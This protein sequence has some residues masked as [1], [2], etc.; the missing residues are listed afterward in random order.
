[1]SIMRF[2]PNGALGVVEMH[3][4][5]HGLY[6]TAGGGTYLLDAAQ[7]PV[8]HEDFIYMAPYCPQGFL[9]G[10]QGAEYLL[11]KDVMRDGF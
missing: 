7:L 11:Y 3:E 8:E 1:M 4:E 9:A 5:E 10:P 2:E 6:M